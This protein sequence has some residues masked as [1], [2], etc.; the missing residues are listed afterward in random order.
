MTR[1]TDRPVGARS[2]RGRAVA[3]LAA[4]L[5]AAPWLGCGDSEPEPA[6]QTPPAAQTPAPASPPAP[7]QPVDPIGEL[8]QGTEGLPEG[9]PSDLPLYPGSE[10]S[11]W[12]AAPGPGSMVI[13]DVSAEPQAVFDHFKQELPTSGWEVAQASQANPQHWSVIASK[14]G[15][16]ARISIAPSKGGAQYGIAVADAD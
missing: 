11:R 15:R 16:N 13:F 9:F 12:L 6:P 14:A 8:K 2:G 7:S 5:L 4:A 1:S 10:P 3:A